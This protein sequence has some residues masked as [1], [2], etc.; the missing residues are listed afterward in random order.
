MSLATIV[1]SARLISIKLHSVEISLEYFFKRVGTVM[2]LYD[3]KNHTKWSSFRRQIPLLMPSSSSNILIP[4]IVIIQAFHATRSCPLFQ[5]YFVFFFFESNHHSTNQSYSRIWDID[6]PSNICLIIQARD[7]RAEL[8]FPNCGIYINTC[9]HYNH[10]LFNIHL[11]FS[12]LTWCFN[13]TLTCY[14]WG[15]KLDCK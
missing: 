10:S 4:F 14:Y 9:V 11:L 2:V 13:L 12:K 15:S 8:I 3:K 5:I 6:Y 7:W 1:S